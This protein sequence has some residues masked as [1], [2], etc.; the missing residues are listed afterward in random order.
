MPAVDLRIH[1]A[2]E[3]E[4]ATP[5]VVVE[6][7]YDTAIESSREHLDAVQ[8]S[9]RIALDES[10]QADVTLDGVSRKRATASVL[11]AD[12]SALATRAVDLSGSTAELIITDEDVKRIRD[13]GQQLPD[14]VATP[15][16]L[17]SV[18][19]VPSGS[20]VPDYT[21][22]TLAVAVVAT[23]QDLQTLGIDEVLNTGGGTFMTATELTGTEL[24]VLARLAWVPTH[25][26]IDGSFATTF[27]NQTS[28][29]WLWWLNG[30]HQ[31]LGFVADDLAQ[32]RG[33]IVLTLPA[34]T[35]PV[36]GAPVP[37]GVGSCDCTALVPTDVSE[38]ELANNP[39]VYSEDPGSFCR[40]FSNPERIV[41]EKSFSVIARVTQP[42]VGALGSRKIRTLDVLQ[43]EGDRLPVR[44]PSVF[45][46][47]ATGITGVVRRLLGNATAA[48]TAGSTGLALSKLDLLPQRHELLKRYDQLLH[49]L[50]GGRSVMD[51]E[52][53][54]QW[55]DDIAQY[56]ATE[57]ALG[58]ILDFRVRWRS[59]GYSLGTVAKT[60]TLAPRQ[61]RRI[62][63]VEWERSE[64]AQR[65]ER[66]ALADEVNDSVVRERDFSD[67]VSAHL[68]EWARGGSSSSTAAVA[69]GIGFA[70]PGILG[71]IGGG[72]ASAHSTSHQEGGRD[73]TASETQ[74]L[75][76]AI[77]RHGD[78]LRRFESTVVNE[79]SQEETVTG[80]TE[81]VRNLNYAHS[82]TVIYYQILRHLK[83]STEFGGAR[84][85]VFVP[86][87]LRPFDVQ[88]AY[89]W[90]ESIAAAIRT[91]RFGRALRYIK[92][93]ATGFTTSDIDPGPRAGQPLTFVRGS[94]YVNLG[95]ERP[96]DTAD[97]KFNSILWQ[98]AQPLLGAPALGIFS[99]LAALVAEQRDAQF[100]KE[101]APDMAA[102]WA[103]RI[104]FELPNGRTLRADCTLATRYRFNQSVR[105]DFTIPASELGGLSRAQLVQLRVI[106]TAGLPPGSVANMTRLSIT[107]N[108]ARFEHSAEGRSGTADLVKPVTGAPDTASAI[109]PLDPWEQV[110]ERLELTR[111]VQELVEHLN[112]H[113][114]YYHKAIWWRM[115]RDRLLM[116]LDGFYVPGTNN[117]SIASIV[118]RE[119][120]AIIGNCLVYRVGA[121]SFIPMGK[122]TTPRQ[123]YEV[124]ADR[125]PVAD[126][127]HISLPT[128]G[129]YAQTI[130]DECAA[131]EEHYGNTDWALNDRD[132]ELG[133]IDPSLLASRATPTT[134]TLP[135]PFPGTII[136]L[137]NAPDAPAP[138]GLAGVLGAVTNA[139]AFRDM[140]GLAGTQANARAALETAAGLA[141]NFGNQAAALELAKLAKAEQATKDADRK[142]ASIKN[143]KDKGLTTE[144]EAAAQTKA[145]LAAMNPDAVQSDA[146][147]TNAAINSAIDAAKTIPGSTIEAT[148]SEGSAK[149]TLGKDD[150]TRPLILDVATGGRLR[151]FGGST[152]L[153]GVTKLSVRGKNLPDGATLRW[154]IPP[155]ATGRYTITQA[156][157]AGTSEVT[158][159][160]IQPGRTDID[161][162]AVDTNGVVVASMKLPLSI[163]QFFT[164]DDANA[165]LNT[166]FGNHLPIVAIQANVL[167]EA[168]RVVEL[169][170][171]TTSNVRLVWKSAG[172]SVPAHVPASFV[173]TVKIGN[174]DI[175]PTKTRYG[176]S[177][178]GPTSTVVG[179]TA[180]DE[181]ILIFPESFLS[182]GNTSGDINTAVNDLVRAVDALQ[183]SDPEYEL[184][185]IRIFG[186][187]IGETTAHEMFHALLPVPFTHTVD[188]AGTEIGSGDIMDAGRFRSLV[189]RTGIAA[190]SGPPANL[191]DNLTDL[192]TGSINRL[193]GVNLTFV[194]S[195]YPIPPAKP[196]DG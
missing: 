17:R 149:V 144:Q 39:G 61:A 116:M 127:L 75:K 110:D 7:T 44:T 137:Q 125:A 31:V 67:A 52:H 26:S 138:Q 133:S 165:D 158:I 123:L 80:T 66:T 65:R 47:T 77:R 108:T 49:L 51:A 152:D 3:P 131:L 109:L 139:N 95:V 87:A 98:V 57:V 190:A 142:V 27:P 70:L 54:L 10:L 179:D 1:P 188:G 4:A 173:T 105:I 136:N 187:L 24:S 16:V 154:S 19:L 55:E 153:T 132:P 89:R 32:P 14:Q 68:D 124:Y 111:A 181:S 189:E 183:S 130:M 126:P 82:L 81:V 178:P 84:Q 73:T 2:T 177:R 9:V 115:D 8:R 140:A 45:T 63:K 129:L 104:R 22:S 23:A 106:A 145:A 6:L 176:T 194:Q 155:T 25:V 102:R 38:A 112:E 78:A 148:N 151:T 41:S 162:E 76:D 12:G 196:F 186:R 18:R 121:A 100:Q 86:F 163:P 146:P 29:G 79:V 42:A 21:R 135:T 64:R 13:G 141:T 156:T 143:A 94:I 90:R 11:S 85:C 169:I 147:H 170:H 184:W 172:S 185:L 43:L 157:T 171:T 91:P 192:G 114:E 166:F 97:G 58:H 46:Q 62:Q 120:L 83:V 71:G 60:L 134:G 20:V 180:F 35:A 182:G 15:S 161:V 107:Y 119:P 36:G 92:D 50:P 72:A 53:P 174:T 30:E 160:G 167:A 113:V 40:P 164:I 99:T 56:Q 168:R 48:S 96:G 195:T 34:I 191:L 88:R 33:P 28:A 103:D 150:D 101:H 69:G 193:T 122:V 117:V 128:D 159:S 5:G 37:V 93:V 59:N 74:R 118:D 175:D